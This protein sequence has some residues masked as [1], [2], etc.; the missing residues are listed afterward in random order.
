MS[1]ANVKLIT[2]V[3]IVQALGFLGHTLCFG[4]LPPNIY[5]GVGA[6]GDSYLKFSHDTLIT[7]QNS[8]SSH[9]TLC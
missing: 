7:K 6:N 1:S 5:S 2:E 8:A 9:L 4:D 3:D